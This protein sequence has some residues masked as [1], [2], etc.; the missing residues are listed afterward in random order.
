MEPIDTYYPEDLE[1]IA[2]S[3][4][5]LSFSIVPIASIP[6]SISINWFVNDNLISVDEESIELETSM[7]SL[8]EHEVKVVVEDFTDLVRNDPSDLLNFEL[9]WD[10]IIECH[11]NP[12]LNSDNEV[13]IQDIIILVNHILEISDDIVCIDLNGDGLANIL[14]VIFIINRILN[15]NN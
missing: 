7:Y 4:E 6:N 8:G 5:L 11:S 13:N 1:P 14:D 9:V 15:N 3:S 12:D 10:L 2:Q